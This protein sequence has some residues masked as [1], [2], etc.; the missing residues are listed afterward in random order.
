MYFYVMNFRQTK[1]FIPLVY[2]FFFVS[3]KIPFGFEPLRS[4]ETRQEGSWLST[5]SSTPSNTVRI[6]AA[7]ISHKKNSKSTSC[8]LEKLLEELF[9]KNT[10]SIPQ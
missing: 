10:C 2:Q 5:L 4:Q 7:V 6:S 9:F 3:A 8:V 1:K